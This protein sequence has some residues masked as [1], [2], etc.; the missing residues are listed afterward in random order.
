MTARQIELAP[1]LAFWVNEYMPWFPTPKQAA[2][3][4]ACNRGERVLYGGAAGGGKTDCLLMAALQYVHCPSYK[5][6]VIRRTYPQLVGE[7]GILTRARAWGWSHKGAVWRDRESMWVFPSGAM[8]SFRHLDL[9]KH[10][11]D[12]QGKELHFVGL[13]EVT[14]WGQEELAL[15]PAT[16]LRRNEAARAQGLPL[17]L[18]ATANP[19][20]AGHAWVKRRWVSPG[21]P[22]HRFIAARLEDNPYLDADE[23]RAR[24]REQG[25]LLYRRLALGDWD[26]EQG[27]MFSPSWFRVVQAAP[28]GVRWV[29]SLD[30]A[31][32]AKTRADQTCSAFVGLGP[33]GGTLYI[34]DCQAWRGEWPE[35]RARIR[36]RILA[37]PC[38]VLVEAIGGF[39]IAAQDLQSDPALVG[40]AVRAV[41]HKA[42]KVAMAAP[43]AARAEAGRVALVEG[44]WVSAFLDEAASFPGGSHDDRIDAVSQ[45]V[46]ALAIP[47]GGVAVAPRR[48]DHRRTW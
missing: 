3:L 15:Y 25:D 18:L 14:Q 6:V 35:S 1:G 16:R 42:D 37:R 20:G 41:K 11:D 10:R 21:Q 32:S 30:L 48:Q 22:G 19:G 34:D 23:Y 5:G 39:Q 47:E 44:A 45:A 29:H 9:E 31:T 7:D 4:A 46:A 28:P 24:L 13:D 2:A 12:Y 40:V 33:D 36:A 17:R 8:L 27:S 38:P 43:W 26:A